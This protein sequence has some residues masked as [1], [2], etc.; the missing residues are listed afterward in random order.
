MILFVYGLAH[1]E[2]LF[3]RGPKVFLL[4]INNILQFF[5][6][7]SLFLC[8]EAMRNGGSGMRR[9]GIVLW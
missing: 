1:L 9:I 7:V 4:E 6:C 3:P 2:S 5:L 8:L